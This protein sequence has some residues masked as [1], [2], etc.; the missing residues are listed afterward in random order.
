[1]TADKIEPHELLAALAALLERVAPKD[2]TSALPTWA[3]G[4][5]ALSFRGGQHYQP[6]PRKPD[7]ELTH[8]E[9]MWRRHLEPLVR[10]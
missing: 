5:S 3:A 7:A 1:M 10:R 2:A 4:M 8:A 9:R 6:P